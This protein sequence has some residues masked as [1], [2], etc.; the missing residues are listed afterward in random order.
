[1]NPRDGFAPPQDQSLSVVVP[2]LDEIAVAEQCVRRITQVLSSCVPPG[3]L[4]V[5]DDGSTDGTGPLLDELGARYGQMQ[6]VHH[7][8]NLGYGAALK[9]GA[10]LAAASGADWVLFMDS[11]LTNPPED[12]L[13]F[14]EVMAGPV[15]YVKGSRYALGGGAR[16]VPLRRRLISEAGNGFSRLLFSLPL[17]D[18]TNGFRAI[19]VA[20][21]LRMPLQERGFPVIMEEAYWVSRMGL[22]AAEIPT[23]L[24]NR[25]AALRPSSF[26]Y[27]PHV[28]L[29]YARYPLHAFIDRLSRRARPLPRSSGGF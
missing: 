26:R 21:F 5:V 11:D 27:R 14:A 13:R 2:M 1:M 15:D 28:L 24:A 19:R 3:T 9:S 8:S 25:S 7:R 10:E 6:V 18:L 29:A 16:G 12:I 4:I 22:R 17:S 23:V 20:P